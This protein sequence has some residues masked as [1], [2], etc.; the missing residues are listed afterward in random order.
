M[1]VASLDEVKYFLLSALQLI[2]FVQ[3]FCTSIRELVRAC[4]AHVDF[5]RVASLLRC[6]SELI[7]F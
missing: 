6:L 4:L 5:T 7:D 3:S 1:F 2:A